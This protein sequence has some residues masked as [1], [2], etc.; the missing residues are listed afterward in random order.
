MVAGV[1]R[2]SMGLFFGLH[3]IGIPGPGTKVRWGLAETGV[4]QQMGGQLRSGRGS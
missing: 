4:S 2:A 1:K 3:L